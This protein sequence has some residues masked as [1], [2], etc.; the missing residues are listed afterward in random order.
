MDTLKETYYDPA[1]TGSFGGV[2]ALSKATDNR[3]AKEWLS[4]QE[5]YT[6][7][8]PVRR[9]Y[10][11]RK[12]IC[13]GLDHLW[14]IDLVD[15]TSL[16]SYN[17]G[18]KYLLTC[19]DC[20]SRYAWV[21]PI[22]NKR[23]SSVTDAFASILDLRRPTYVQSD[24]GSEFLNS[25]FQSMLKDNDILFYTSKNDDIK[26][27]LVERYNRT[28]KTRMWRY[29]TY[30]NTL[31]YVDVLP[32]LV[33]SYNETEHG[34]IKIAPYLVTIHNEREL[35]ERT[36][37]AKV[38]PKLSVGDWVRISETRR[39]FKKGYLPAWTRE[40]FKIVRVFSTNPVTYNICDSL[41]E[42]IEGKFYEEELQ[43]V[44]PDDVFKIEKVVKTR[45]IHGKTQYFVRWLGYPQ[46][47]DSWV[48]KLI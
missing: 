14:Q 17:D 1:K 43:K 33:K 16:S 25:S 40:L 7:H 26:C 3:N 35:R 9:R 22:R 23:S 12:T 45:K 4:T 44:K 21:V 30:A 46:K 29:F 2:N 11:R 18:F 6:L 48:D 42:P 13:V 19:I 41:D 32:S 47:F 5:T 37:E 10:K 20:F 38:E 15:M 27:A 8:K 39:T 34:S 36:V 31:R 24:K 28:L